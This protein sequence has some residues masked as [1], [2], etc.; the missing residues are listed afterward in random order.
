MTKRFFFTS[1]LGATQLLG[2]AGLFL[3]V[4]TAFGQKELPNTDTAG[5]VL[6]SP[7]DLT[8]PL[9]GPFICAFDCVSN[10]ACNGWTWVNPGI[11]GPDPVCW[12]KTSLTAVGPSTCCTSGGVGDLNV[13]RPGGDYNHF[14]MDTPH[15]CL[16]ACSSDPQCA[17]W[18]WVKPGIQGPS[19][20]CWLKN[21]M[22]PAVD[23]S[24]CQSGTVQ[25]SPPPPIQ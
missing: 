8:P 16:D 6:G 3:L 1:R 23:N 20:V 19:G 18:S 10:D 24:C 2:I 21:T 7:I 11:Q 25:H 17:A 4:G 13:D 9:N 14:F 22:P 15:H 5:P 12:L